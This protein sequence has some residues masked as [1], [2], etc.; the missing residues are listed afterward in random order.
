MKRIWDTEYT[1]CNNSSCTFAGTCWRFRAFER[2]ADRQGKDI[3]PENLSLAHFQ[4]P[5]NEF[6]LDDYEE[7]T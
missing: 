7:K 3:V 1:L 4:E 6:I 2:I 5:C